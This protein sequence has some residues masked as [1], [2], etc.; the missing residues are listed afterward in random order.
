M[1]HPGDLLS[2]LLDG[3]LTAA[4]RRDVHTHLESCA[5]CRDEYEAVRATRDAVRE[6][7]LLDLPPGLLPTPAPA[8][9]PVLARAWTWAAAGAAAAALAIGIGLATGSAPAPMDLDTFAEHHT[10]RVLVQPGFQTVRAD[11]GAP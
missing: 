2:A 1:T 9:R 10:A 6:L 11:V 5:R 7:P 4:E 8:R 3:E